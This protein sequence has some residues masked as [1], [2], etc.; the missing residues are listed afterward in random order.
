[1]RKNR[2][3][4][5]VFSKV[6]AAFC[7]EPLC[8]V[9]CGQVGTPSYCCS[10]VSRSLIARPPPFL[11]VSS[12]NLAAL[13][14]GHFF[15][16]GL[17]RPEGVAR[18]LMDIK[19]T[20]LPRSCSGHKIPRAKAPTLLP[21]SQKIPKAKSRDHTAP[22]AWPWTETSGA[23]PSWLTLGVPAQRPESSRQ[24]ARITSLA[25]PGLP[26]NYLAQK[27]ALASKAI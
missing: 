24:I 7:L 5:T 11:G 20:S 10:A 17:L 9:P 2:A 25:A 22:R 15:C 13:R 16:A 26:A 21:G 12:L 8:F 14:S 3:I 18:S 4:V 23:K 19:S 27:C 1:M 6:S